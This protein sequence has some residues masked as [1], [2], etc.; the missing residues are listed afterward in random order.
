[1]TFILGV[2]IVSSFLVVALVVF[3]CWAITGDID[4]DY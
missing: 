2:L 4:N 1:M 3:C